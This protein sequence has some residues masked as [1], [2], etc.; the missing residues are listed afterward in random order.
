MI[1]YLAVD[2]GQSTGG[3]SP[4]GQEGYHPEGI[5]VGP[6]GRN[7]KAVKVWEKRDYKNLDDS[8]ELGT[9][10]IKVA[11]RRLRGLGV[12]LGVAAVVLLEPV[13][14]NTAPATAAAAMAASDYTQGSA[15]AKDPL[16]L[17]LPWSCLRIGATGSALLAATA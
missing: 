15:D 12:L 9:R 10:N 2:Q 1:N 5:R 7:K 3:T 8:V 14:R 13:A 6:N 4:F 16:L 11:L 17:V